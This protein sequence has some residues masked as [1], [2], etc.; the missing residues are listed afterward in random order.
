MFNYKR[1]TY[2]AIDDQATAFFVLIVGSLLE[3]DLV[4]RL[5]GLPLS[6]VPLEHVH[7]L[8]HAYLQLAQLLG[9]LGRHVRIVEEAKWLFYLKLNKSQLIISQL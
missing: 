5:T 8:V 2:A 1:E 4:Q 3:H 7:R 9:Y 6:V